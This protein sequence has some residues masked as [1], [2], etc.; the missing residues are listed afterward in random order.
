MQT[1]N[2]SKHARHLLLPA[3]IVACVMIPAITI[4]A[5]QADSFWEGGL[6]FSIGDQSSTIIDTAAGKAGMKVNGSVTFNQAETDVK[7][8]DGKI[9]IFERRDE[10]S[11]RIVLTSD[12]QNHMERRY[13]VNGKEHEFDADGRRWLANLIPQLLRE[14]AV[15]AEKRVTRLYKKGG[16]DAVLAEIELIDSGFARGR[17]INLASNLGPLTPAQLKRLLDATSNIDSDFELRSALQNLIE[18]QKLS[19]ELQVTLL[20]TLSSKME[21]DFELRTVLQ[22]LTPKLAQEYDVTWA[23]Q[24]AV[25]KIDSD[26]EARTAILAMAERDN[27]VPAQLNAALKATNSLDSDFEHRAALE[28]LASHLKNADATLI[29]SYLQSAQKIDSDFERRS[30]LLSLLNQGPLSKPGYGQLLDALSGM[31][32]DF[33]VRTVL[34]AVARQM[35]ADSELIS[36]YRMVARNLDDFERGQ[37]EKALDHVN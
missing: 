36:H 11:F 32:S 5:N 17:Y 29:S 27:L 1:A 2:P 22:S 4:H 30:A 18:R 31:E 20:N 10:K 3:L 37:A 6:N 8:L 23:W 21:S 34:Q 28:A 25:E 16:A 33:E 19:A 15:D 7:E 26:F 13:L 35:P 24:K 9:I 12:A 14:S